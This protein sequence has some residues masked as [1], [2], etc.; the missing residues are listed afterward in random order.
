MFAALIAISGIVSI[1]MPSTPIPLILQNMMPILAGCVLG[2]V[3]GAGATGLFLVAGALGLPIFPNGNA[4]LEHLSSPT[5]GYIIGYFV[6]SLIAGVLV[7]KPTT[8]KTVPISKIAIGA[9]VGFAIIYIIGTMQFVSA[10]RVPIQEAILIC[11]VPFLPYDAVKLV[12]TVI[13][14]VRVRPIIDTITTKQN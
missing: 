10:S 5:G 6:S 14:S 9:V 11:I 7:G 1:Q 3:Q 4:G 2:G 12:I 8:D 13:I